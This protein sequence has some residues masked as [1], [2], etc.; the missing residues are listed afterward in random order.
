MNENIKEYYPKFC[1]GITTSNLQRCN[2]N[3]INLSGSKEI[4]DNQI[5]LRCIKKINS[6]QLISSGIFDDV[7]EFAKEYG[8]TFIE[9]VTS[10]ILTTTVKEKYSYYVLFRFVVKK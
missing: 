9:D 2:Q 6:L 3:I 10:I 1:I 8:Y 7:K 4:K 5:S